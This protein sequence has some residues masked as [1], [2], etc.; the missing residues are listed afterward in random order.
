MQ[1]KK[2]RLAADEVVR[3]LRQQREHMNAELFGLRTENAA[4]KDENKSLKEENAGL[5][6]AV[7]QHQANEEI[8]VSKII[9]P[10]AVSQCKDP[11]QIC[12]VSEVTEQL[13]EHGECVFFDTHKNG[14]RSVLVQA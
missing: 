8:S 1:E 14:M 9:A 10:T 7:Q 11:R 5:Q 3:E 6:R 2:Q 4:L 13:Q 12:L